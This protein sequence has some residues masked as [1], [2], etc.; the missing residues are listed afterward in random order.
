MSGALAV[1]CEAGA[2]HRKS[3]L[4]ALCKWYYFSEAGGILRQPGSRKAGEP[5]VQGTGSK[6]EAAGE[7]VVPEP[8]DDSWPSEIP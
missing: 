8:Q 5:Q 6:V 1:A 2:R 7:K 4:K 3:V